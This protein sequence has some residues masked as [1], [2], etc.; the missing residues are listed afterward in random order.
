MS[1]MHNHVVNIVCEDCMLDKVAGRFVTTLDDSLPG[2][3]ATWTVRNLS[4]SL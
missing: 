2:R 4:Q 1:M 3:L